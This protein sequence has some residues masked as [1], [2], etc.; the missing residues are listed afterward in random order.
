MSKRRGEGLR[1]TNAT[2]SVICREA[3]SRKWEYDI[4]GSRHRD[5]FEYCEWSNM[6]RMS[7]IST[8]FQSISIGR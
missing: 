6:S 4:A 1:I 2:V 7:N 3:E 5:G 8:D